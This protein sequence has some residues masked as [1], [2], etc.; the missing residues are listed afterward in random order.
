MVGENEIAE[1]RISL[2]IMT[3]GEQTSVT[4]EEMIEIL[5]N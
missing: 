1:N 2:K 5:R 4:V 3:T